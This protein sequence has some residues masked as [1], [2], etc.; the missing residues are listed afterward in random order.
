MPAAYADAVIDNTLS[1]LAT[2]TSAD[3]SNEA[4]PF[5]A[6]RFIDI[7]YAR[8]LCIRITYLGELG[9]ELYVPAEHAVARKDGEASGRPGGSQGER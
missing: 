2:V 5:R 1:L 4:F 9:Y 8:V 6:A 7:G 3:I